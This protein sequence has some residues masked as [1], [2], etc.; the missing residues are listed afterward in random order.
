MALLEMVH[1]RILIS[2]NVEKRINLLNI[3]VSILNITVA[4]A[5][6]GNLVIER[7]VV[8]YCTSLDLLSH[9]V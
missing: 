5:F 7:D 8:A 3:F 4:L 6:T 2:S 9:L 1:T